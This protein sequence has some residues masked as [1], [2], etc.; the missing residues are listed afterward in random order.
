V[1]SEAK[2]MSLGLTEEQKGIALAKA[3]ENDLVMFQLGQV[4]KGQSS[5]VGG[6]LASV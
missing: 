5:H 4:I 3:T 2:C 1:A 6:V